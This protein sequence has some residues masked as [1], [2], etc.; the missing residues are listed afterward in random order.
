MRIDILEQRGKRMQGTPEVDQLVQVF[1][2]PRHEERSEIYQTWCKHLIENRRSQSIECGSLNFV[3]QRSSNQFIRKR[4]LMSISKGR[5]TNIRRCYKGIS[6]KESHERVHSSGTQKDVETKC[7][8]ILKLPI[9]YLP[10]HSR[11]LL[12]L[13]LLETIS[14]SNYRGGGKLKE[15]VEYW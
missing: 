9:F 4:L 15:V 8:S 3:V 10:K 11:V 12:S 2:T 1:L 6:M 5:N 13:S 14:F 7:E